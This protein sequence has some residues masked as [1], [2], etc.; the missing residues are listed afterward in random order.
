MKGLTCLTSLTLLG[1]L[2]AG[3]AAPGSPS[4]PA[5]QEACGTPTEVVGA[6]ATVTFLLANATD[7]YQ[8][9]EHDA[10]ADVVR[11]GSTSSR[12][13]VISY[14]SST[15]A[16]YPSV[17]SARPVTDCASKATATER[18]P[19][20]G[21][22]FM[23]AC[24][25]NIT[26]AVVAVIDGDTLDLNTCGRVRLALIDTPEKGEPGYDEATNYTKL[27][28]GPQSGVY[29]DRDDLQER[30]TTGT[31]VVAAL[32]CGG[33]PQP[34]LNGILLDRGLAVLL[35]EFC[36]KSEFGKAEWAR[37]HGCP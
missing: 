19:T 26:D 20:P 28:C 35:T 8:V 9:G 24:R 13:V 14:I 3:C 16:P 29:V 15:D 33:R 36:D 25:D 31:R 7:R 5:T 2:L 37:K 6:G 1:A 22:S 32:R 18:I 21:P 23:P 27:A 17:K 34:V 12:P 4:D 10:A 30:D 11:E